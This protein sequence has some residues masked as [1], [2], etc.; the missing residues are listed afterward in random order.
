MSYVM[1]GGEYAQKALDVATNYQ[2]AYANGTYGQPKSDALID[3]RASHLKWYTQKYIAE[4]KA[5]PSSYFLFDCSGLVKGIPWG[6]PNVQY[7]THGVPDHNDAGFWD[8]C[9][10]NQST[11]W[12]NIEVGELLHM[13]GHV[14]IYIGDGKG[15]ECTPGFGGIAPGVKITAVG[16]IGTISGFPTRTWT[17][18]G[19][20][21]WI[22]YVNSPAPYAP[23]P[24]EPYTP[25]PT[26]P[27]PP[28]PTPTPTPTPT[29]E[30][31]AFTVGVFPDSYTFGSRFT[32]M[33]TEWDNELSEAD[34]IKKFLEFDVVGQTYHLREEFNRIPQ[35]YGFMSN[36]AI[37]NDSDGTEYYLGGDYATE[38]N[39]TFDIERSVSDYYE[40]YWR[41]IKITVNEAWHI[42]PI[43]W[44]KILM[45]NY[46]YNTSSNT[47]PISSA[48]QAPELYVETPT[49]IHTFLVAF[50]ER[51]ENNVG[52]YT[53]LYC[54]FNV[55]DPNLQIE[56]EWT[57]I[58][59]TDDLTNWDIGYEPFPEGGDDPMQFPNSFLANFF[60]TQYALTM[61]QL[62]S[63]ALYMS[64]RDCYNAQGEAVGMPA[65]WIEDTLEDMGF[66]S[67]SITDAILDLT[68]YPFDVSYYTSG[69]LVNRMKLGYGPDYYK[70][71]TGVRPNK[72]IIFLR[73]PATRMFWQIEFY[74]KHGDGNGGYIDRKPSFPWVNFNGL[75]T[76]FNDFRDYPPYRTYELYIPFIGIVPIDQRK[77]YG[78]Y[79]RVEYIVDY[80]TG[81]ATALLETATDSNGTGIVI[82]DSF[83]CNIGVHEAV[84]TVNWNEYA[85]RVGTA[86]RQA[87]IGALSNVKNGG[88]LNPIESAFAIEQ[89]EGTFT[90]NLN[91]SFSS[92][93]LYF[94][95]LYMYLI[96]Y[97]QETRITGNL[98]SLGG[99]KT[100]TSGMISTFS[101]FLQCSDVDLY[102]PR[103]TESEKNQIISKLQ[104][105]IRIVT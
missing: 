70:S 75:I 8:D 12:T 92:S 55:T 31:T 47:I 37:L 15:V 32:G 66:L 43:I 5:L 34:N 35:W 50:W 54:L 68:I 7:G 67:G 83:D 24:V 104:S 74:N 27:V 56:N 33:G 59:L 88:G 48:Y 28:S 18:H 6:F 30:L 29:R 93:A 78:K 19:K 36:R 86:R 76:I 87:T 81:T 99:K 45:G 1:T 72:G 46:L 2:T 94:M 62:E 10:P 26:P 16:N 52:R 22:E 41:S 49:N 3:E 13:N 65:R 97:T 38:T 63:I 57:G 90:A 42:H 73:K 4:L 102:C 44:S 101:G 53:K 98:F 80:L 84:S 105:G 20:L 69:W 9:Y 91:G 39:V 77:F 103:A 89:S 40:Y 14:G 17:G 85:S 82:V 11:D 23:S 51:D 64:N 95:P 60:S 61:N 100:S 25:P 79:F 96:E 58:L 21:P 71:L